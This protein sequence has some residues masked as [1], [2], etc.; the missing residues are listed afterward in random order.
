MTG[1]CADLPERAGGAARD[2]RE[3][4]G[5]FPRP[6]GCG[7]GHR[8]ASQYPKAR[9]NT[10]NCGKPAHDYL[11][12][13][14]HNLQGFRSSWG[15]LTEKP[16]VPGSS[17][18]SNEAAG[19]EHFR[20]RARKP[21]CPPVRPAPRLGGAV[22]LLFLSRTEPGT[23]RRR[24]LAPSA[25]ADV[26]RWSRRGDV[27][28]PNPLPPRHRLAATDTVGGCGRGHGRGGRARSRPRETCVRD[29][30]RACDRRLGSRVLRP[31]EV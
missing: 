9:A 25:P 8:A 29:Q 15:A 10:A 17:P 26:G 20:G 18:R 4:T 16:R 13:R 6:W 23:R 24:T 7:L 3:Q 11:G 19:S 22:A 14:L 27:P 2:L 28:I 1:E 5:S 12:R 21:R 31:G 30:H